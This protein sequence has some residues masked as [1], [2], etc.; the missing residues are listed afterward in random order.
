MDTPQRAIWTIQKETAK[1]PAFLQKRSTP[2]AFPA[3]FDAVAF[4]SIDG[5]KLLA[6]VQSR[7]SSDD[8]DCEL[9]AP[10]AATYKSHSS[11][12]IDVFNDLLD[13]VQTQLDETRHSVASAA[14]TFAV[15]EQSLKDQLPQD[16]EA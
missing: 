15:L 1:I 4:S 10:A 9:S 3:V 13:K 5:Q 8:D 2:T 14:H 11:D 7:Q 12:I 16:N 6:L